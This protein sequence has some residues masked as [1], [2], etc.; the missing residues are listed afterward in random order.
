[1]RILK[2]IGLYLL[3]PPCFIWEWFAEQPHAVKMA[4]LSSFATAH[5]LVRDVWKSGETS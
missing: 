1:M 5:A 2:S 4:W 3:A